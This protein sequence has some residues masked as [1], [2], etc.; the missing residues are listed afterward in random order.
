[1]PLFSALVPPRDVV[2]SVRTELVGVSAPEIVRWS[3]PEDWH[4]TLGF[5]GEESDPATRIDW[6]RRRLEGWSAPT[7]R[8][9]GAGSFS[10]VL[11]LGVY[12][13]GLVELATAVGAGGER[14][15][16]PH[17]T[18]ART[19]EEVPPEL[20]RRLAQYASDAWT[21]TDVVLMRSDR[22][23]EGS[24]YSV[25]ETFPLE[26]GQAGHGPG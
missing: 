10:H 5:Y 2:E 18:V 19:R 25:V 8:L 21:A 23:A 17:L 4:V 20:S 14:P 12:G 26:S 13:E 15:Y 16:L 9:Q 22:D 6:L 11:Y 24:R 1:M 3:S 7:L